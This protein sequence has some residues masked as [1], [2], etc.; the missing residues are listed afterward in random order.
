MPL[1]EEAIVAIVRTVI[2]G[3]C[4]TGAGIAV[5]AV[6]VSFFS[7]RKKI[8]TEA[9]QAIIDLTERVNY[10]ERRVEDREDEM[11]EL[12]GETRYLKGFIDKED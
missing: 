3:L 2:T 11:R 7:K 4:A 6:A 5:L 1:S 9:M 12:R 10:L 8:P